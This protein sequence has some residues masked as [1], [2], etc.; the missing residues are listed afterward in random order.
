MKIKLCVNGIASCLERS[1]TLSEWQ[2]ALQSLPDLQPLTFYVLCRS[3]WA[4]LSEKWSHRPVDTLRKIPLTLN[5]G[6]NQYHKSITSSPLTLRNDTLSS[7]P[8]PLTVRLNRLKSI[9]GNSIVIQLHGSKKLSEFIM[10]K[11]VVSTCE[12]L[13]FFIRFLPNISPPFYS[14]STAM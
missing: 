6:C 11:I 2:Y 7:S 5:T 12:K 9:L 8:A 1:W 13:N 10:W 4:P 14:T 3:M